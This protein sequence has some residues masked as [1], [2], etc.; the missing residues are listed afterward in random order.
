MAWSSP[1]ARL[2]CDT[3]IGPEFWHRAGVLASGRSFGSGP[4]SREVMQISGTFSVFYV[5]INA[6]HISDDGS[7][8]S[9]RNGDC[10]ACTCSAATT[11]CMKCATSGCCGASPSGRV[12]MYGGCRA[13][14]QPAFDQKKCLWRTQTPA[15]L[16]QRRQSLQGLETRQVLQRRISS[17]SPQSL[18]SH[19]DHAQ[20]QRR[21]VPRPASVAQGT[22]RL[23]ATR[24]CRYFPRRKWAGELAS[25]PRHTSIDSGASHATQCQ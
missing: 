1:T 11:V 7:I 10:H 3:S 2:V 16:G 21:T 18:N 22:K 19:R 23:N 25:G 17:I 9:C 4:C 14:S 5:V 15:R 13:F 6:I 20:S 24:R 8:S 12:G